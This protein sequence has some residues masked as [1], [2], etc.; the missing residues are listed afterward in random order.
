MAT[1]IKVNQ[2]FKEFESLTVV[3]KSQKQGQ[4][5]NINLHKHINEVMNH[6]VLHCP[7]EALNKLEEISYL[8]KHG[9]TLAIEDFL[10]VND[11]KMYAA[12]STEEMVTNT[13]PIIEKSQKFFKVSIL[14]YCLSNIY[15]F[16]L[17]RNKQPLMRKAMRWLW[18]W[19]R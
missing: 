18:I 11:P 12:P 13:E 3:L 1:D 9:D 7:T 10:K 16:H 8:I 19:E 5:P 2:K 14:I 15:I 4:N 6:I 17:F